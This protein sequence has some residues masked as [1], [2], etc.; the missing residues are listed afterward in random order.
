MEIGMQINHNYLVIQAQLTQKVVM[1]THLKGL[2][3]KILVISV[4][5]TYMATDEI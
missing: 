4:P 5:E 3:I 1:G 2:S